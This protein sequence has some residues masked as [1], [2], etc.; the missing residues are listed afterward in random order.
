MKTLIIYVSIHHQNT[1]K[2]AQ[3]LAEVLQADLKN[4]AEI[5]LDSFRDYDLVGFGSGIYFGKNHRR[6]YELIESL[7]E[8]EGKKAFI[9]STS[10]MVKIFNVHDFDLA[11]RKTLE[12]RGFQVI[13]EFNCRGWD[14]YPKLLRPWGGINRGRPDSADF[15]KAKRFAEKIIAKHLA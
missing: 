12:S 7:P 6:I 4:P 9:F 5:E 14:S 11:L 13:G 3:V 2:I 10:G 15:E 1:A 8:Q